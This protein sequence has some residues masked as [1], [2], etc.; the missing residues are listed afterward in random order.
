MTTEIRSDRAT[1]DTK[2]LAALLNIKPQSIYKRLCATKT[3]WGLT[4][5]KL[6]N[7]RLLWPADAVERLKG[8]NSSAE[9]SAAAIPPLYGDKAHLTGV[10]FCTPVPAAEVTQ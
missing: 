4:P 6:P 7:G 3:Y 2:E 1:I 10:L 9:T 5:S 8:S